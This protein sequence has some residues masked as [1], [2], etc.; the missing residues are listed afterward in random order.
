MLA[1]EHEDAVKEALSAVEK[2]T[3]KGKLHWQW[4]NSGSTQGFILEADGF[5]LLS[6]RGTGF[7][8]FCDVTDD[9]SKV[10]GVV[11][12][13][14]A[15]AK[16]ELVLLPDEDNKEIK[17][18]QGFYNEFSNIRQQV[19]KFIASSDLLDG[20]EKP[21]WLTGHSLGACIVTLIAYYREKKIAGL[22]TFGSPCVGNQKFAEEFNKREL[23]Q[24]C[25]RYVNGNDLVANDL[26]L[27]RSFF[28]FPKFKHVGIKKRL[29]SRWML[30]SLFTPLDMADHAPIYYALKCQNS[31]GP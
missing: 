23:N 28:V 17:V 25:Y 22:Y 1:Y 12:D 5:I 6:V 2:F 10:L 24:L 27:W 29:A 26:P 3:K 14:R 20:R 8:S 16:L 30:F 18:A 13:L 7:Y 15:D 31:L 11:E 9:P 4:L 21:V 19:E